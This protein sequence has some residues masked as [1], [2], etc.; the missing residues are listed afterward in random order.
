[1]PSRDLYVSPCHAIF[2][3][4]VL[5]PAADLVNTTTITQQPRPH[6]TYW[7]IELDRHDVILAEN[8]PVESFLDTNSRAD[9]EHQPAMQ[10]HPM[11]AGSLAADEPCAPVVRQGE[12]LENLRIS[13]ADRA[14]AELPRAA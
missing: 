9:F 6:I 2:A 13:L 8:L 5:I 7:H 12:A 3:E 4:G 1:M 14:R 10:L 11:F